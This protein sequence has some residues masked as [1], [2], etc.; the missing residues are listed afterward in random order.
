M[1]KKADSTASYVN[2]VWTPWT[3]FIGWKSLEG[4]KKAMDY[5]ENDKRKE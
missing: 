5:I 2:E 1:T 4:N 3:L